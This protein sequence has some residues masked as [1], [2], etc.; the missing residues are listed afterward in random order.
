ML[1]LY[2]LIMKG[3]EVEVPFKGECREYKVQDDDEPLL[4]LII[5]EQKDE[6]HNDLLNKSLDV[7]A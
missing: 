3:P 1:Q 4:I 5:Q 6:N 2:Y 7:G